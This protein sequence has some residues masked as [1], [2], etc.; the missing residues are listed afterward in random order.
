LLALGGFGGALALVFA[1]V[2]SDP[3]PVDPTASGGSSSGNGSS[4]SSG[5]ADTGGIHLRGTTQF[6]P[7]EA[8]AVVLSAPA[9]S[10]PG[11]SIWIAIGVTQASDPAIV[12]A[13]PE[14]TPKGTQR[15]QGPV[16]CNWLDMAYFSGRKAHGG[17][18]T[19]TFQIHATGGSNGALK[20]TG[21]LVDY[22]GVD[23]L[24]PTDD[25]RQEAP[26]E[27]LVIDGGQSD[28]F[29]YV[30]PSVRTAAPNDELLYLVGDNGGARW[31]DPRTGAERLTDTSVLAAFAMRSPDTG[32][33]A[34]PQRFTIHTPKC[35]FTGA[36]VKVVALR[37]AK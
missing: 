25:E 30:M 31:E 19:Y 28:T 29:I 9:D 36:G 18:E 35:G 8:S 20:V 32:T 21:V 37:P 17:A 27:R 10:Q 7:Q 11:D 24:Q 2:G 15:I 6:P 13:P 14:L 3:D 26:I 16:G 4:S 22:S 33:A 12:T 23:E 1:C 5:G 34:G